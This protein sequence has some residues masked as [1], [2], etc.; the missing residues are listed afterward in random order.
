MN[1]AAEFAKILN[2]INQLV[3]NCPVSPRR[4]PPPPGMRYVSESEYKRIMAERAEKARVAE[5]AKVAD[6]DAELRIEVVAEMVAAGIA[7]HVAA[8]L[9][10]TTAKLLAEGKK[11]GV[12]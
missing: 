11:Y 4:P 1:E 2:R 12:L 9:T 5:V 10:N 8:N 3:G 6:A 7:P